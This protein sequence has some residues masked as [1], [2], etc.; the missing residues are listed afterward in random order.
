MKSG[1]NSEDLF[2]WAVVGGYVLLVLH[3]IRRHRRILVAVWAGVVG[4]S[5]ALMALLPKT[6]EVAATL[7]AQ[8]APVLS[9]LGGGVPPQADTPTK[10]AAATVMQHDNL[11][12]L[13]QQ[14]DLPKAWPANRAPMLRLKD[15]IW[16]RLFKPPTEADQI[17]GFVGLL[18]KRLWVDTQE[19]TVTIGIRFPDPQL[20][21]LLVEGAL[22]NF[23]EAR[24]AAEI[25]SI[26]E[27]ISV[28]ESRAESVH[29]SL[30][31]S[32]EALQKLRAARDQKLGRRIRAPVT[33]LLAPPV[34]QRSSQLLAEVESKRRAIS[35]LEDFRRRRI[36]E[37]ETRL[38]E[39][40]A[41]YSEN[42]P[43][44]QD[45][46]QTLETVRHESPQ[47]QA[48]QREL[49]PLETELR[50]RGLLTDVP[51]K[52]NRARQA[53]LQAAALETVNP[54]EA[55][56][57]D[58][59]YAK[60]QLRHAVARYN[61]LLDRIEA[62]RLEEDT[63]QA[64]FKYRYTIIRPAQRPKGP[65]APKAT[66]VVVASLLSGFFLAV[67]GTTLVDLSSR[68]IVEPWQVERALG[69][70]LLGKVHLS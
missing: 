57:P 55:E 45:T 10:Q 60:S 25:T 26:G 20:A 6:Y 41:L 19:G 42:H 36:A 28:L 62:A 16:A 2:D 23:L 18:E 61:G 48:L 5:V 9:S 11:V 66:L 27:E 64:A 46:R 50:Q 12:S 35:D 49:A 3:S 29:E 22:D 59:E 13:V 21:F 31:Q 69:V 39:L 30:L 63:A 44:V 52:A 40:K 34:D 58:I 32:L 14:T 7:Q 68:K 17:E 8:R 38:E 67:L 65:I 37:L 24:H 33:P 4:L 15:A 56:D 53:M 51:L 47:V 70:E 43:T 54:G 1:K